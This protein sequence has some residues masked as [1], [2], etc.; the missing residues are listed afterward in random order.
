MGQVCALLLGW[1]WRSPPP[2]RSCPCVIPPLCVCMGPEGFLLMNRILRGDEVIKVICDVHLGSRLLPL[3]SWLEDFDD[4]HWHVC[5]AHESRNWRKPLPDSHK[6]TAAL[7]LRNGE[8]LNPTHSCMSWK[9]GPSRVQ[10]SDDC[11]QKT[12]LGWAEIPDHRSCEII[13][14]SCL[15]PLHFGITCHVRIEK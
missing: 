4:T 1:L 5:E 7:S 9:V 6:R 3:F 10:P 15:K 2:W 8:E 11:G 14:V 13:H 12:Q